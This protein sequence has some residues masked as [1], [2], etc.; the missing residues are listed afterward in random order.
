MWCGRVVEKKVLLWLS[1]LRMIEL[2]V[3]VVG[4]DLGSCRLCLVCVD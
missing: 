4:L 1:V 3:W 2:I